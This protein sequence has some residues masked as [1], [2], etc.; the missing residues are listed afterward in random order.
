MMLQGLTVQ[1]LLRR[2][3]PVKAGETILFHAAAG[4]VG[5]IACQ[6]AKALRREPHRHRG[7]GG[8]GRDR[9][10]ARLRAHDHLHEGGLPRPRE[11]DHR[12]QGRAGRL[13]L[14]R[15]GHLHEVARLP[16]AAR[17]HGELRQRHGPRRRVQPRRPRGQGLAL[18]D[19][20]R[21]STRTS[22]SARNCWPPRRS[23]STTCWPGGS[24]SPR[25]SRTPLK[26]A[27]QAHRDLEARKTTGSTILVP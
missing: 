4:G 1:Y 20:A 11:G 18:R 7:L 5:L 6:W 22:A 2:T 9:A 12:R 10:R 21:R 25:G 13:R 3:Y 17:P 15:Q 16:A 24:G 26:D 8:E 19:A 14:D 27:A 23:S